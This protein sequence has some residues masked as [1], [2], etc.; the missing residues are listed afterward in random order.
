MQET[1]D[2][3]LVV[4]HDLQRVLNASRHAAINEGVIA[5]LTAEADDL[6]RAVV[7][8]GYLRDLDV[9]RQTE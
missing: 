9:A 4:L 5:D 6:A 8:V 1:H 3:E 2:G 7:Q